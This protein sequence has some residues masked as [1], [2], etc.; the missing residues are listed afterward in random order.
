MKKQNNVNGPDW[1]HGPRTGFGGAMLVLVTI[2][3]LKCHRVL[4]FMGQSATWS[5][6][7]GQTVTRTNWAWDETSRPHIG[8]AEGPVLEILLRI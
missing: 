8:T 3:F 6:H 2:V 7:L 4:M 1:P 5:E